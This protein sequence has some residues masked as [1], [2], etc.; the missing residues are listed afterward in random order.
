M[1]ALYINL[2]FLCDNDL[3]NNDN[4]AD[5]LSCND[6]LN[7]YQSFECYHTFLLYCLLADQKYFF[8]QSRHSNVLFFKSGLKKFVYDVPSA[9]FAISSTTALFTP[10]KHDRISNLN[11]GFVFMLLINC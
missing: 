7:Y 11:I 8:C 9:M 3:W 2:S 5:S 1:L 6:L 10:W 4:L